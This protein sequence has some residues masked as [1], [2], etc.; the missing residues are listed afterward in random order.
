MAF[1]IHALDKAD[2][3][4]ERLVRTYVDGLV[5]RFRASPEAQALLEQNENVGGWADSLIEM[6]AQYLGVGPPELS[7]AGIAE[8]MEDILPRKLS[9]FE[10]KE[11][12][13]ATLELQAFWRYLGREYG[14]PQADAIIRYLQRIAPEFPDMMFDPERFG[15]AKSFVMMGHEAGFD[16]TDPEAANAFMQLYNATST[17][18]GP[19]LLREMPAR[20]G[21]AKAR[22]DQAQRKRRRKAAKAAR[23]RSRK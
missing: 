16:M 7:L 17:Y 8:I 21:S 10:R 11:A 6:G 19:G 13:E 22:A 23:R 4:D 5:G 15:M 12:E 9:I 18:R 14:L 2:E 20:P 1:D 3:Q